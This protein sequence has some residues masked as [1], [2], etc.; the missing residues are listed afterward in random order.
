MPA[1][2]QTTGAVGACAGTPQRATVLRVT[3][4]AGA[5]RRSSGVLIMNPG[6]PTLSDQP[7]VAILHISSR[8]ARAEPLRL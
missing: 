4:S 6:S 5:G 7:A 2:V 1:A 3:L 8:L